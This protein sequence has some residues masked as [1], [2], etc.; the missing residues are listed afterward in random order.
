MYFVYGT[1]GRKV[2]RTVSEQ[3]LSY[4]LY[5]AQLTGASSSVWMSYKDT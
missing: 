1:D 4:V 5:K 3:L 2:V